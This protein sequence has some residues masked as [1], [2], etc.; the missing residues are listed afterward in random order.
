VRLLGLRLLL[1]AV[2]VLMVLG[3]CGDDVPDAKRGEA[4]TSEVDPERPPQ[5]TDMK[6]LAAV[7]RAECAGGRTGASWPPSSRRTSSVW[8]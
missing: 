2:A 5:P 1:A 8:S 3:G 7:S 4:A 6:V